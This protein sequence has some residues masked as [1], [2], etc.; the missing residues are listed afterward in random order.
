MAVKASRTP[1]QAAL[2]R[3]Q[4][5]DYPLSDF[6]YIVNR[7]YLGQPAPRLQVRHRAAS[8]TR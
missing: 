1:R 3:L 6:L 7:I 8:P 4:M 5:R 2:D